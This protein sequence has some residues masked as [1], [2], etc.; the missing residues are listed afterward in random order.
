[1]ASFQARIVSDQVYP[2]LYSALDTSTT[3]DLAPILAA[4]CWHHPSTFV[5]LITI[6]MGE[7]LSPEELRRIW[8]AGAATLVETARIAIDSGAADAVLAIDQSLENLSVSGMLQDAPYADESL[9]LRR[10]VGELRFQLAVWAFH[11]LRTRDSQADCEI[12]ISLVSHFDTVRDLFSSAEGT[13][14]GNH[15]QLTTWFLMGIPN[16]VV[17]VGTE[18]KVLATFVA[19]L[20]RLAARDGAMSVPAKEW[21]SHA[22]DRVAEVLGDLSSEESLSSCLDLS[23]SEVGQACDLVADAIATANR[24][25]E[26]QELEEQAAFVVPTA[27]VDRFLAQVKE[28]WENHRLAPRMFE[29]YNRYAEE[30]D[31]E[32]EPFGILTRV[33]KWGVD[34]DAETYARGFGL[35]VARDE[36]ISVVKSLAGSPAIRNPIEDDPREAFVRALDELRADGFTPTLL[37]V[38]IEWRLLDSLGIGHPTQAPAS[39]AWLPGGALQHFKGLVDGIQVLS[40]PVVPDDV[41]FLVDLN[42]WGR[43]IQSVNADSSI[44]VAELTPYG[45]EEAARAVAENPDLE[46]VGQDISD[47]ERA[48]R[49]RGTYRLRVVET[50]VV[51]IDQPNAARRIRLSVR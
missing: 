46:R 45:E 33:P 35:G 40:S 16:R 19:I 26:R 24:T 44:L 32:A 8:F 4:R 6:G 13:L 27:D 25:Q 11:R 21:L 5:E 3:S 28:G 7:D 39:P 17:W 12:W 9:D 38:P 29:A 47:D 34:Q 49:L 37:L 20:I 22:S 18:R 15:G 23:S 42:Q 48:L 1:L 10:A 43:W 31:V 30:V 14:Q 51:Q 50:F 41:M 2:M 36:M